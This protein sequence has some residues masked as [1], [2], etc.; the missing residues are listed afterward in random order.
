L[1]TA[2]ARISLWGVRL[3]ISTLSCP[4]WPLERIIAV[5][6][7][8][9]IAG[10][11]FRGLQKEIDVTR[12]IDFT[13]KLEKT[14]VILRHAGVSMPC[15]STS[16]TLLAP[17][18]RRWEA[19]IDECHRYA[20]LAGAAAT[21][22]LRIFGGTPPSEL[23]R[24]EALS[25]ARR[26]LRQLIK[27]CRNFNVRP[28]VETHDEW[29]TSQQVLELFE[30]LTPQDAGVLWDVEHPFRRGESPEETVRQLGPFLA[31]VHFKDSVR[32]GERTRPTLLGQ[33]EVPLDECVRALKDA[34]YSGWIGLETERRWYADAPEPEKSIPHFAAFMN[35][36]VRS[37]A[38]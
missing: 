10:I 37:K 32:V 31:H 20:E 3:S 33:G 18:G 38:S 36:S 30:G 35:Q 22:F 12:L 14:L 17:A 28:L 34:G 6:A 26:R 7:E 11:E 9:G 15:L 5:A 24:A 4:E 19:M 23:S 13:V 27:M 8:N 1:T 29:S 25:L 21:P 2:R 16:V